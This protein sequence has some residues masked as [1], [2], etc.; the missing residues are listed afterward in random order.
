M[1]YGLAFENHWK[2][3]PWGFSYIIMLGI[4]TGSNYGVVSYLEFTVLNFGFRITRKS[5]FKGKVPNGQS[6]NVNN[7]DLY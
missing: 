6:F 5:K 4:D 3:Y 1:K 2:S 7:S